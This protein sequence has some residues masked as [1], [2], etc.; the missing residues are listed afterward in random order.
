[1]KKFAAESTRRNSR[2]EYLELSVTMKI[3]VCIQSFLDLDTQEKFENLDY[4]ISING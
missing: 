4:F 3:S 1:M 2:G